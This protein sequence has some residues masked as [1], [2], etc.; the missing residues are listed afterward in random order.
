MNVIIVVS[1]YSNAHYLGI[2]V[3]L[4]CGNNAVNSM[5][6]CTCLFLI[7]LTIVSMITLVYCYFANLLDWLK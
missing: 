6:V 5:L 3:H 1:H 2:R 7:C 4:L